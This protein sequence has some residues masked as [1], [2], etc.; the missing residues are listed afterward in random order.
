MKHIK[1]FINMFFLLFLLGCGIVYSNTDE[2]NLLLKE[3]IN[4]KETKNFI[5]F[6][7]RISKPTNATP[8]QWLLNIINIDTNKTKKVINISSM[9][10]SS[11]DIG[12]IDLIKI[13]KWESGKKITGILTVFG[14]EIKFEA[15]K[16]N[17]K[18]E[19]KG[20]GKVKN[21]KSCNEQEVILWNVESIDID[22]KKI[23][24]F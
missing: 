15:K 23:Q 11:L 20:V 18:W 7:L 21:C 12:Y 4:G 1:C 6:K 9:V 8:I 22:Y 2:I 19:F 16:T 13:I 3:K 24:I 14:G 5:I 10:S 17:S